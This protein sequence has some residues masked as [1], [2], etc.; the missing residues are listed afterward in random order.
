MPAMAKVALELG[1]RVRA[2]VDNDKPGQE[3]P[4][5]AE[6]A[7]LCEQLV[8]LPTRTAVEAALIR[9]IP[10]EK[11]RKIVVSLADLGMPALPQEVEDDAI[12][13][14]LLSKKI[15]KKHGLGPAWVEALTTPP[16]TARAVIEAL[17]AGDPGRI[18]V[19]PP[20]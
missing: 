2:I 9:G 8:V 4:A 13:E 16:P 6:L 17:C 15:L 5:V 19:L 7:D 11:L 10:G 14:H 12:A 18:D 20:S 3:D 1:F